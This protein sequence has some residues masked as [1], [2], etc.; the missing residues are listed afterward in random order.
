MTD[1]LY[2]NAYGHFRRDNSAFVV[3][4]VSTPRPWVN[5]MSNDRYG[6]MVSQAG[7]GMSWYENCQTY[8]MTRW[9][10]D[11]VQDAYGRFVYV[12]ELGS[13][14][15]GWPWSTTFQPT[16]WKADL[17]QCEHGLGYTVFT[18]ELFDLRTE[19]TV[20]VP[21]DADAELWLLRLVNLSDRARRFRLAT[22]LEWQLG[23]IGDWH[24]EFHRL[25]MESKPRGDALLAWKHPNLAEHRRDP[26]EQPTRAVARWIGAGDVRWVTDKAAWLGRN[27]SPEQPEGL[28]DVP[29]QSSTPRWDDPIAAG[30]VEVEI[31]PGA[32]IELGFMI[33][34]AKSEADALALVGGCSIDRIK[35]SLE[36]TQVYWRNRC[37]SVRVETGDP[38]ID[39]LANTWLPYQTIAGRLYARCAYYQQGGAY[40]YR[41]QLQDSLMLLRSEPGETLKQLGRHAEQMYADGGVKHWWMPGPGWGPDSHHSD[42]CL[43]LAYGTLAYL[44]A[45]GDRAC[46]RQDYA[47]LAPT[48]DGKIHNHGSLLEHCLRGIDRALTRRSVRGLPLIGA[49]DW[50]DGLSHAGIDGKGE[51][52]WLAMFLYGILRRISPYVEGETALRY[53]QAADDLREAVNEHAWDGEWYLGGTRDDGKPFGSKD[54]EE[55]RI[56][57]NPQTWAVITGIAPEDR[58]RQALASAKEHL[59]TE[60]GALLLQPAYSKVDPYIGYI[61]RYAPGLRENGGVYSHASTWAVW[62]FAKAGD[63]ETARSIYRGMLPHLRARQDPDL[64]AAEPY[65]MP[66]NTDGPDSPYASRAGWTWYTG[67][68]AWMV[69]VA[70]MLGTDQK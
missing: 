6:L 29:E 43:W 11:L 42:T 37:Q 16:R 35:R 9:E 51:S 64:Y 2:E 41:D 28:F 65:V 60:Y 57:L 14:E 68:S 55:G 58:A 10:Q 38:D 45:T 69:R 31:G 54:C 36:E 49:G 46:L 32:S 1:R 3:T 19:H 7:G 62:A 56:F 33:G 8:R 50:N 70:E 17:D 63:R 52:V 12:H 18:R 26:L 48:D 15:P 25:F 40:G 27:G 24:R 61:T 13:D 66:G 21:V 4:D 44:D 34:A 59:V 22:Y 47:Y 53:Q 5:V 20:F 23:G 30:V 39:F 67:S